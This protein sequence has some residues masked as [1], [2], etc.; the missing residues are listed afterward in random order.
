MT[1][2]HRFDRTDGSVVEV[3]ITSVDDGDFHID[4]AQ[5]GLTERRA[6]VMPGKWSVVR[7]VHGTDVREAPIGGVAPEGDALTTRA[8]EVPI[9]VQGADCA[10]I[11]FVTSSGPIAVA[12]V[13]WR[14]LVGGVIERTV[15][16]LESADATITDVVVGPLIGAE[17]Y[18]FSSAD[19]DRVEDALDATVRSTTSSGRP[20]LDLAAGIRVALGRTGAP[21]PTF[22]SG[23]TACGGSGFSH[24][25]RADAE[26]HALAARIHAVGRS[27]AIA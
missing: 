8:K 15:G 13:G 23:C 11:A 16:T 9:A 17:C 20:A 14:G 6:R 24:R 25:A 7:Q 4:A 12:H 19:L 21:D 3:A 27:G 1:Q 2:W 18:E 22:A 26:R 5:P 10:P